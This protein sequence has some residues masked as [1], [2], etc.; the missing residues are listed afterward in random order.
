MGNTIVKE[1]FYF[2]E[3]GD[4]FRDVFRCKNMTN[5]TYNLC[6]FYES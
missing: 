1:M 2:V 5:Y 3:L 6:V 4:A